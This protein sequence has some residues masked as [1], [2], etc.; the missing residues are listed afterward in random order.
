MKAPHYIANFDSASAMVRALGRYLH[1]QDFPG[2]GVLP[3][4]API[5]ALPDILGERARKLIYARGGWMETIPTDQLDSI[6]I[7]ELSRWVSSLYPERAY[8]AIA[9]GS[10]N[11]AAIHL[12]AALG[13]PWL[14]QT[15]L[16]PVRHPGIDPDEPA[17]D[18]EWA[19][20]PAQALLKNNPELQLHHMH[21]A[22]HDR[23]MIA[24]MTYFRVKRIRLGEAYRRFIEERL[25]P[26]GTIISLECE[27]E[28]PVTRV[29]DRHL[30]QHGAA[31][32]VLR[33]EY[34]QGSKRVEDFLRNQGSKRTRWEP[35][36]ADMNAP[37]AEWG[38]EPALRADMEELARSRGYSIKRLAFK[39]PE[40]LT[41]LV[42][43]L[44]H[45]WYRQRGIEA[46]RLLVESFI[47]MDPWQAVS[48]ASIPYWML[49]NV[50]PSADRLESYLQDAPSYDEIYLMLFSHGV[51]SI[52]VASIERWKSMLQR[53]RKHGRFVGVNEKKYP[54]DIL[55]YLR[56]NRGLRKIQGR[57]PMPE[58]LSLHQLDQFI[59]NNNHYPVEFA[60][61]RSLADAAGFHPHDTS[62]VGAINTFGRFRASQAGANVKANNHPMRRPEEMLRAIVMILLIIILVI[63]I[64]RLV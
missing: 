23:L 22:S 59:Q 12:C 36:Q 16:I 55:V 50:E 40:D 4:A 38:F 58:P 11:G 6:E 60:E 24:H 2:L 29:A 13:I 8:P 18:M 47:V 41:P 26:G 32:G 20:K 56:Y 42:A 33:E 43:E 61:H 35:P 9:I 34:F 31:G 52:G 27:L 1:G 17:Q 53:A 30:F 54:K 37:E 64:I 7:E 5:A 3:T 44:Y 51:D 62:F 25:S 63:I 14:P 48:T 57:V 10:S 49:F 45:W 21:D 39:E 46:S 19:V 28:W 15:F